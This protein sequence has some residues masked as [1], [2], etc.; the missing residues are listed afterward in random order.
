VWLMFDVVVRTFADADETVTHVA[1]NRA[2]SVDRPTFHTG[3]GQAM[4]E[5][6]QSQK[7]AASITLAL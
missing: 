4:F 6:Y 5:R 7:F 2:A 1:M 3:T